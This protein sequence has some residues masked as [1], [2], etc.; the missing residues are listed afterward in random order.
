[1]WLIQKSSFFRFHSHRIRECFTDP[2]GKKKKNRSA[3][4]SPSLVSAY[5]AAIE[6]RMTLAILMSGFLDVSVP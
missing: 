4:H 6:L 2:V 5:Q 3:S 1:M